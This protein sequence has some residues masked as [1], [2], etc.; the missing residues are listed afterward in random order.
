MR[1]SSDARS[2]PS[3]SSIVRNRRPSASPRSYRRQTFWCDTWR[4]MRSSLWNCAS[5]S[6]VG[7]DAAGQELQGDRVV[8]RQIVGAVHLAH[9]APAEHRDQA[10]TPG[11]HRAWR[12][13]M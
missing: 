5:R 10:I 12:E 2:S 4:A 8:E 9:A 11:N 13:T 3:T 1:R 6:R 7:G